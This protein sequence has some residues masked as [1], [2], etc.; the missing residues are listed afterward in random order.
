M[1][2]LKMKYISLFQSKNNE[3]NQ[4]SSLNIPEEY[5]SCQYCK[6]IEINE[7]AVNDMD[8]PYLGR[9]LN[10]EEDILKNHNVCD[11]FSP[12]YSAMTLRMLKG[13]IESLR[14]HI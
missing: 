13:D 14:H 6:N 4:L 10:L 11:R 2:V 7:V 12:N 9:C 3:D 5:K 8:S 1:E